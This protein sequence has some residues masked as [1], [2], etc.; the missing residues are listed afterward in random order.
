[1]VAALALAIVAAGSLAA[2]AAV[3][4][5]AA[6]CVAVE[7]AGP[8]EVQVPDVVFSAVDD[9]RLILAD[10]GLAPQFPRDATDGRI[11]RSQS[12]RA[13]TWVVPGSVVRLVLAPLRPGA[14]GP[15][16][17]PIVTTSPTTAG[18]EVTTSPP[19]T[20]SA[21]PR[22]PITPVTSSPPTTA[23]S[24]TVPPSTPTTT[25]PT[26]PST[27]PPPSVPA[28]TTTARPPT[29]STTLPAPTTT[30]TVPGAGPSP[31]P[32]T[33]PPGA[34]PPARPGFDPV[35]FVARQAGRG[36]PVLLALAGSLVVQRRRRRSS[37]RRRHPGLPLVARLGGHGRLL[38]ASGGEL[39]LIARFVHRLPTDPGGPRAHDPE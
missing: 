19:P 10:V 4:P 9:A 20:T 39:G 21:V 22:P 1:M 23:R 32:P 8:C 6:T 7:R 38:G 26:V 14:D 17:D 28:P 25:H 3:E 24:T 15:V 34:P 29:T 13:G 36:A 30:A 16:V 12:P 33:E 5:G 27:R 37:R 2:T 18:R 31:L 11:V 35:A